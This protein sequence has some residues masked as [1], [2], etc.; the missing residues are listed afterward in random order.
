ML[1]T[2]CD[3]QE[4]GICHDDDNY[5]QSCAIELSPA[6]EWMRELSGDSTWRDFDAPLNYIYGPDI[7]RMRSFF[8]G[9]QMSWDIFIDPVFGQ[10]RGRIIKTMEPIFTKS[11]QPMESEM[12]L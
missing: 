5:C 2:F 12:K 4:V 3:T 9:A 11:V 10:R 8:A 6:M 1:C 7:D